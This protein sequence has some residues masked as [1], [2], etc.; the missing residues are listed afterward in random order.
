[1]MQEAYPAWSLN[2]FERQIS[3]PVILSSATM[4][5]FAAAGRNN[6]TIAVH[7]RR[8]ADQPS[9]VA[10]AELFQNVFAP[11]A[12]TVALTQA[13]QFAI[14][15][16]DIKSVAIQSRGATRARCPLSCSSLGPNATDHIVLPS[17]RFKQKT[18]LLASL[19]VPLAPCT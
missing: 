18:V 17:A 2:S 10:A 12:R 3:A 1:M 4:P 5:A 19:P 9:R 14:L 6:Q 7:Q 15:C 11:Y 16:Q 8:F 13:S